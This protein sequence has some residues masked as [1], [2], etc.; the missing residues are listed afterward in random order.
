MD[1]KEVLGHCHKSPRTPHAALPDRLSFR[2]SLH[3]PIRIHPLHRICRQEHSCYRVIITGIVVVQP[4]R[5]GV[6]TRKA[7]VGSHAATLVVLAAIGAIDLVAQER[8]VVISIG[9][10]GQDTAQRV[11]EDDVGLIG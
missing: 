4:R 6:V 1:W 7:L 11:G 10:G 9:E 8:G 3:I 2:G 5:I